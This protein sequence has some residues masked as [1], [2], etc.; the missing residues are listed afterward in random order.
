M[1]CAQQRRGAMFAVE[2]CYELKTVI[3]VL[4]LHFCF[5]DLYSHAFA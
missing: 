2:I 3:C 5:I 1:K 4:I